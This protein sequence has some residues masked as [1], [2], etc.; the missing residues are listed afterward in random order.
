MLGFTCCDYY[1]DILFGYKKIIDIYVENSLTKV[2]LQCKITLNNLLAIGEIV[3]I[4]NNFLGHM[5]LIKTFTNVFKSKR[6]SKKGYMKR[7]KNLWDNW[8]PEYSHFADKNVCQQASYVEKRGYILEMQN[9]DNNDLENRNDP[10]WPTTIIEKHID[11]DTCNSN[12]LEVRTPPQVK[13][14]VETINNIELY[15]TLC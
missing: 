15:N 6:R 2:C 10:E 11:N 1:L 12:I 8:H 5:S 9:K 3:I 7:I 4:W 14:T 13:N